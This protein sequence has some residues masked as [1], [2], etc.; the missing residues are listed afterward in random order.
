M[1]ELEICPKNSE[2]LN[3]FMKQRGINLRYL[4]RMATECEYNFL[5]ELAVREILALSIKVLVR[6]GLSFLRDEP[7]GYTMEDVK[8]CVLHYLNEIFTLEERASSKQL[9]SFVTDLI[10]SKFG[11]TLEK[12]II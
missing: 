10:R 12:D 4:G 11:I 5:K 8:K 9:W 7:N 1:E 2:E 6:D 3:F